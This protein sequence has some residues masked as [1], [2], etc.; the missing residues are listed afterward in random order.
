LE[1]AALRQQHLQAVATLLD[2]INRGK[3]KQY[4]NQQF[5]CPTLDQ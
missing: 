1:L 4:L 3:V 5:S 2:A